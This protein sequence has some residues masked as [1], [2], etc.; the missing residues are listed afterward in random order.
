MVLETS[1]RFVLCVGDLVRASLRIKLETGD[2]FYSHWS[3]GTLCPPNRCDR[4][5]VRVGLR[6]KLERVL[7]PI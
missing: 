4:D 7:G 5:L 3:Q 2:R 6:M 1:G